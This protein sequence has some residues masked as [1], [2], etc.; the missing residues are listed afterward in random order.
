MRAALALVLLLAL[1]SPARGQEA[2]PFAWRPEARSAAQFA[3]DSL[4][5]SQATFYAWHVWTAPDRKR[6]ISCAAARVGITYAATEIVKRIVRRERPDGSD[7]LSFWSGHAASSMAM[8][9]WRY[10]IGIPLSVTTGYLRTAANRHYLSDVAV[11][12]GVG[13]AANLIC[14]GE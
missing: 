14:R 2:A 4:L 10:E 6:A 12:L 1:A 5:S 8:A 13:A 11:G 7:R 9:G 3:S